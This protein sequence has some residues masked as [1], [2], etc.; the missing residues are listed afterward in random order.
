VEAALNFFIAWTCGFKTGFLATLVFREG[1][2]GFSC[3][4]DEIVGIL[5]AV[6]NNLLLPVLIFIN[7][8]FAIL[9]SY[10]M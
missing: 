2:E 8:G 7:E 3:K 1:M 6:L 9:E 10:N 4:A 5:Y